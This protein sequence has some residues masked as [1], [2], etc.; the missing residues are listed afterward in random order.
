[1]VQFHCLNPSCPELIGVGDPWKQHL[2]TCPLLK[3][4][5]YCH[6]EH[7]GGIEVAKNEFLNHCKEVHGKCVV[8]VE[9]Y[10]WIDILL[11]GGTCESPLNIASVLVCRDQVIYVVFKGTEDNQF[12]LTAFML[13]W[14]AQF[15]EGH[16][17]KVMTWGDDDDDEDQLVM[18]NDSS[19]AMKFIMT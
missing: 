9:P 11:D 14:D 2:D 16:E 3:K 12:R 18:M 6:F 17:L 13:N 15:A 8:Y 10:E 7:C 5:T 1:M 19:N 4:L